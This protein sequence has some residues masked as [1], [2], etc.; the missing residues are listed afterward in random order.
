M[1]QVRGVPVGLAVEAGMSVSTLEKVLCVVV[2]MGVPAMLR[3]TVRWFRS[4]RG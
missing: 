1:P 4:R 2:V 3:D